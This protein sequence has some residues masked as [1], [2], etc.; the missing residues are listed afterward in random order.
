M[1]ASGL[2]LAR[3]RLVVAGHLLD[4]VIG[5]LGQVEEKF[6]DLA[7]SLVDQEDAHARLSESRQ[8]L[9]RALGSLEDA[10]TQLQT[11]GLEG[12]LGD[13]ERLSGAD[14]SRSPFD[15]PYPTADEVME[16]EG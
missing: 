8:H 11:E 13:Q 1:D 4:A 3:T 7:R 15:D 5:Q 2:E 10:R 14:V 16:R 6:Y 12:E 9:E